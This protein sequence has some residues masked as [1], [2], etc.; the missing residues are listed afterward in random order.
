MWVARSPRLDSGAKLGDI[1]L[2]AGAQRALEVYGDAFA[3]GHSFMVEA[4]GVMQEFVI[5]HRAP[6]AVPACG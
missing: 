3:R 2:K 6:M 5:E 4:N 1:I